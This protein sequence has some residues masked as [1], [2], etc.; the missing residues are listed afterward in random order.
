M[1]TGWNLSIYCLFFKA[2]LV[3]NTHILRFIQQYIYGQTVTM[4]SFCRSEQKFNKA[5]TLQFRGTLRMYLNDR[6]KNMAQSVS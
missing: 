5:S 6:K 1:R 2:E 3:L 4:V